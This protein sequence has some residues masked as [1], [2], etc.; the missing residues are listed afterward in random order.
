MNNN[1]DLIIIVISSRSII[2]DKLIN[3]Y[4]IPF[5]EYINNNKIRITILFMF[6]CNTPL[7][8]LNIP[9]ENLYISNAEDSIT[10]GILIKTIETMNFVNAT[11]TYKH[12]LRT[13]LSSFFILDNL[14]N[15]STSLLQ[16]NVYAGVI[17]NHNNILFASGAGFWMSKDIVDIILTNKNN[18]DYFLNDDVAI[19]KLLNTIKI[20]PMPRYDLVN[21]V[22]YDDNAKLSILNNIIANKHYHIRI[23]NDHNRNID[24]DL[25]EFFTKNLYKN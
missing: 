19:G 25:M 18:I 7:I 3:Q 6:G 15:N 2:Y 22:L 16:N 14:I 13:N 10:P 9:T 11:F 21:N 4:W 1:Y 17:L 12:I 20:T 5:L 23:K 8:D 24:V